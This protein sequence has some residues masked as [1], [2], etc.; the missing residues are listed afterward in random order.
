MCFSNFTLCSSL[1]L[2]L[3][4]FYSLQSFISFLCLFLVSSPS[5]FPSS[6]FNLSSQKVHSEMHRMYTR[7]TSNY[8]IVPSSDRS[9]S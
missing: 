8:H 5:S 3:S 4:A 6:C 9:S 7:G 2:F 1:L